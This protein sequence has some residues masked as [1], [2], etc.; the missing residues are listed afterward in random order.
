MNYGENILKKLLEDV[1]N[2][3]ID[4]Y[5]KLYD[6]MS[7]RETMNCIIIDEHTDISFQVEES[8]FNKALYNGTFNKINYDDSSIY[9][10]D[11]NDYE[12]A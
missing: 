2:M 10:V 3:T 1:K 4:D 9:L 5:V 11:N 12:A 8:F 7:N 6:E